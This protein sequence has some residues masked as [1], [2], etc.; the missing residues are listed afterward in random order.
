MCIVP[1]IDEKLISP[2]LDNYV[3]IP[4]SAVS[5]VMLVERKP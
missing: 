4:V 5:G 2:D 3:V 1:V